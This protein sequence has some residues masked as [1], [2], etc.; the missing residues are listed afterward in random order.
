MSIM[1]DPQDFHR[2]E[3]GEWYSKRVGEGQKLVYMTLQS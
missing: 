2:G 1:A 3:E